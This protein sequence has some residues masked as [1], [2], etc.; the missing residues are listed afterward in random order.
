VRVRRFKVKVNDEVFEVEVEEVGSGG[1]STTPRV[2]YVDSAEGSDQDFKKRPA[3]SLPPKTK[4]PKPVESAG[5]D[6][7][8]DTVIK[9]PIPG[10]VSEV[11]VSS[12]DTVTRGQ[13][14]MLL[15]AMK[16]QNEILSPR[17]AK[18]EEVVADQG[19]SVQTG[20]VLV[21]LSK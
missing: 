9:A 5:P 16:M 18:V 11:R 8:D 3:S 4:E 12:G 1:V 17:D 19:A 20:D 15:E 6:A 21:R 2:I 7:S 13:V 10:V 14:L